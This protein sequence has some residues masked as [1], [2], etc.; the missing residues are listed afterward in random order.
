[1]KSSPWDG[2]PANRGAKTAPG[3]RKMGWAPRPCRRKGIDV[4]ADWLGAMGEK[5]VRY[6]SITP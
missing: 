3:P 2:Q 4:A 6:Q 5:F 1:M